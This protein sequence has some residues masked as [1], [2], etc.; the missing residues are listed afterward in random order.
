MKKLSFSFL[1]MAI[2]ILSLISGIF[3]INDNKMRGGGLAESSIETIVLNLDERYFFETPTIKEKIEETEIV[4][5]YGFNI[6]NNKARY[7][8]YTISSMSNGYN[9][10]KLD[11]HSFSSKTSGEYI[12]LCDIFYIKFDK[13]NPKVNLNNNGELKIR[14]NEKDLFIGI[15]V[16][17]GKLIA[18][19]SSISNQIEGIE[20]YLAD[21]EVELCHEKCDSI[22]I[23]VE[24]H[25]VPNVIYDFEYENDVKEDA[26]EI[27]LPSMSDDNPG[28]PFNGIDLEHSYVE[29]TIASPNV[30]TIKERVYLDDWTRPENCEKLFFDIENNKMMLNLSKNTHYD[31]TYYITDFFENAD[32]RVMEFYCGDGVKPNISVSQGF[33]NNTT[34]TKFLNNTLIINPKKVYV[35]D[36]VSDSE[37]LLKTLEIKV[38]YLNKNIELAPVKE[39]CYEL[40]RVGEYAVIITAFDE[41]GWKEEVKVS[42][43]VVVNF[44]NASFQFLNGYQ[45]VN[46]QFLT[47]NGNIFEFEVYKDKNLLIKNEDYFYR[48]FKNDEEI[49]EIKDAGLYRIE[50]FNDKESISKNIKINKGEF[51]LSA[52]DIEGRIQDYDGQIKNINFSVS[53]PER[54]TVICRYFINGIEVSPTEVGV[55]NVLIVLKNDNYNER[56]ITTNLTI[57]LNV[58]KLNYNY[59]VLYLVSNIILFIVVV[60]L[61]VIIF[62]R[63]KKA[64]K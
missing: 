10:Y 37:F 26:I 8:R 19:E 3:M 16:E 29:V 7:C 63:I 14:Y 41:V 40:N 36:N 51:D 59:F 49:K 31:V 57:K 30:A 11:N 22:K 27:K 2:M 15:D 56:V 43:N 45:V 48:I 1:S 58:S 18:Y 32:R 35:S 23:V 21:N 28:L 9:V 60:I 62:I 55:Y 54:T 42:V 46:E 4:G 20:N 13:R 53:L 64:P 33:V 12:I 44:N 24:D 47:Y 17:N 5:Y 61:L 6:S 50:I 52:L 39:N 34:F 25:R 38:V